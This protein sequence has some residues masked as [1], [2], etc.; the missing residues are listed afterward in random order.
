MTTLFGAWMVGQGGV[1]TAHRYW[2]LY[3]II[4][5]NDSN[6]GLAEIRVRETVGGSNLAYTATSNDNFSGRP[7][8]NANDGNNGTIYTSGNSAEPNKWFKIDFG[9]GNARTI[10]E[11][12]LI[13]YSASVG[14]SGGQTWGAK[15][16]FASFKLEYSDD[17][18]TWASPPG[19]LAIPLTVPTWNIA[20]GNETR[21]IVTGL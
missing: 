16:G 6:V 2:R 7:P 1:N 14:S 11:I 17:N 12:S 5:Q 10:R 9:A 20:L 15:H 19:V 8:T 4:A 18:S 13:N 3:Q 21:D